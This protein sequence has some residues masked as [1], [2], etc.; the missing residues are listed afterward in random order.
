MTKER[1]RGMSLTDVATPVIAIE[2]LKDDPV[3][4]DT[5]VRRS[6][7]LPRLEKPLPMNPSSEGSSNSF[8]AKSNLP[9]GM[10]LSFIF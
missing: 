1:E 6:V 5:A 8:L 3:A 9:S 7:S 4:E 2:R 10:F